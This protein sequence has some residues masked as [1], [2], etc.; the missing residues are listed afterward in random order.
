MSAELVNLM[1][2]LRT[3]VKIYHWETKSFARHKASD[4]LVEKLDEKID[5]FVETYIGRYGRPKF[6]AKTR[7]I[8]IRNYDDKESVALLKEAARWLEKIPVKDTDLLNI[9]DEILQSVYETI[10]LFTFE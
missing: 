1:L 5:E 9:R 3:Q 6:T 8:T 4:K 7:T 10:Y 2:S